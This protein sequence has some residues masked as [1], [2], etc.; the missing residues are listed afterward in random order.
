MYHAREVAVFRQWR[1]AEGF[2]SDVI[3]LVFGKMT[4]ETIWRILQRLR[5]RDPLD[6]GRGLSLHNR[7]EES[8]GPSCTAGL[9]IRAQSRI[10]CPR[11][12][13]TPL[14]WSN[15]RILPLSLF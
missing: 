4:L 6:L 9:Q 2:Q 14:S 8:G 13:P 7:D 5:Q 11:A 10:C 1:V 3:R 15:F 12:F